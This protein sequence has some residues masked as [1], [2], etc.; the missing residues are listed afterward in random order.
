MLQ[1]EE[2]EPRTSVCSQLEVAISTIEAIKSCCYSSTKADVCTES[3]V[4]AVG[5][6]PVSCE[7]ML[8]VELESNL[9]SSKNAIINPT[10]WQW[11]EIV[12]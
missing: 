12:L 4:F 1:Q 5:K 11:F 8:L 3:N 6:K 10:N 9:G 7:I 2:F